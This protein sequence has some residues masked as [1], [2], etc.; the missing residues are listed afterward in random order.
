M[1]SSGKKELQ[2]A[3]ERE[4]KKFEQFY[5]WVQNHMPPSFFEDA[6]AET[7]V[8]VAHSLMDFDTQGF[9]S[10]IHLKN[11]GIALCLDSPDADLR[12][13]RHYRNRAIKNYRTF[14]SNA[15]PPFSGV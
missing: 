13:L 4:S 3:V 11:K 5:S 10:H 9:F 8:L 2:E 15:P 6:D 7:I 14:V 12:I 1:V